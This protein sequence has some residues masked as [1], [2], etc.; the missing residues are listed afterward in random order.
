[1][2]ERPAGLTDAEVLAALRDGWALHGA[3]ARYLPVGAGSYHW[4]VPDRGGRAWFVT[5]ADLGA[6]PGA[7]D[8]TAQRL[9][10]SLTTALVLRRDAGLDFVAAP[11]PGTSGAPI[12]RLGSRYALAVFPMLTGTAGRFGGHPAA[13]RAEV[14][15]MLAALHRATPAAVGTAPRA[16]LAVPGRAALE[17]A[18]RDT[19]REWDGG[20]YAAPAGR[21]LRRHTERI[22]E[23]LAAFD[24]L[25]ERLRDTGP[26]WVVTHG[27]PHPGNL[28]RTPDG[29]RLIDWDTV[30]IAPPERDLWMLTGALARLAGE[31]PDGDGRAALERYRIA[32][33]RAPAP[34]GLALYPL[35]WK[36][37]DV[38]IFVDELRRPHGAG[39][40]T[41]AAFSCLAG[42]LE[43]VP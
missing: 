24:R 39:A 16:D 32:T 23:W 1:M 27:E 5:A 42:Y 28:V 34:A 30:E 3:A 37:A 36:L 9:D 8:A 11:V 7:R 14:V 33:G 40:D 2:R 35:R 12:R 26:G 4:S 20:P 13:D 31:G 10:R 29:L 43:A 6:D 21:L 38:A 15:D 17:A 22:T 19:R 25:A 18:L 41:A